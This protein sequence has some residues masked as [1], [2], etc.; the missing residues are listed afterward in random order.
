MDNKKTVYV[1][2][3]DGI[4]PTKV[5]KFIQFTT[6]EVLQNRNLRQ[7]AKRG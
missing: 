2:F 6:E 5:N 7:A 1:N 4:D 3:F